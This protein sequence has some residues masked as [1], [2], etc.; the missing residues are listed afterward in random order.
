V[1]AGLGRAGSLLF[2]ADLRPEGRWTFR[3]QTLALRGGRASQWLDIAI[4]IPAGR[5]SDPLRWPA[6]LASRG[7]GAGCQVA[8]AAGVESEMEL[9]FAGLH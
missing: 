8:R 4:V 7:G 1:L 5:R 2:F 9:A 6:Q 3:W